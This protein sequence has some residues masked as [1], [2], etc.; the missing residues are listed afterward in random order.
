MFVEIKSTEMVVAIRYVI[1]NSH[2]LVT[3]STGTFKSREGTRVHKFDY[4]KKHYYIENTYLYNEV[5]RKQKMGIP[6]SYYAFVSKKEEI[7]LKMEQ[8]PLNKILKRL[9]N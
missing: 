9:V 5:R 1:M 7:Q 3:Y 8:R 2:N 6:L 4:F